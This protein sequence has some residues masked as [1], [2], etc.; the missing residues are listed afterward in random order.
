MEAFIEFTNLTMVFYDV[1]RFCYYSF[2]QLIPVIREIYKGLQFQGVKANI[3]SVLN[4]KFKIMITFG[5]KIK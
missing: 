4:E 1:F 5:H 3:L 2:S